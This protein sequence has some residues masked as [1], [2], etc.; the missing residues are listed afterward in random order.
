[1]VLFG[2]G[3]LGVWH[4]IAPGHEGEADNW[5]NREHHAERVALPGFLRARRYVNLGPGPRYF[6]RYDVANTDVLAS[7]PYLDALNAPSDWSRRMFPNYRGTVRGAFDV[8]QRHRTADGGVMAAVRFSVAT[9]KGQPNFETRLLDA[10]ARSALAD[11]IVA[12][13]VWRV[14]AATTL[15]PTREKE[16]RA[17]SEGF[18]AFV[19][20]VDATSQDALEATLA[21]SPERSLLEI[22]EPDMMRLVFHGEASKVFTT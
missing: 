14:D 15:Q 19:L 11:G 3:A 2:N 17:S 5:Y 1:M 20:I 22:V 21:A 7:Q 4:D 6:S 12:V 16:L 10:A 13:E 9:V 18:P 8:V